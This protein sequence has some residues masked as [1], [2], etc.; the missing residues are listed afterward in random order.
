MQKT[1]NQALERN[2]KKAPIA[3]AMDGVSF[4]PMQLLCVPPSWKGEELRSEKTGESQAE[5]SAAPNDKP[6]TSPSLLTTSV[7]LCLIVSLKLQAISHNTSPVV[8]E[9]EVAFL[10][11][12][13]TFWD[14]VSSYPATHTPA[15]RINGSVFQT[16]CPV[17]RP[18][19][20]RLGRERVRGGILGG[21]AQGTGCVILSDSHLCFVHNFGFR[22]D[23]MRE[24]EKRHW[25]C[26]LL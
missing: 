9:V 1:Q 3:N 18:V 19:M 26:R 16:P 5:C 10:L 11:G 8:L 25:L 7:L 13:K 20:C 23:E 24:V 21:G 17:A 6:P 15:C 12:D 2:N 4:V 22:S 14:N